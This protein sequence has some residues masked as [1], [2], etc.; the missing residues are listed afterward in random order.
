MRASHILSLATKVKPAIMLF[1]LLVSTSSIEA[2]AGGKGIYDIESVCKKE[3]NV[4]P[5]KFE[6][7][8]ID[9]CPSIVG[10]ENDYKV[11]NGGVHVYTF[12]SAI[13][14]YGDPVLRYYA[15]SKGHL[16]SV[17]DTM[18]VFV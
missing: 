10:T 17:T 7:S 16:V 15:Y 2:L 3:S 11:V 5:G 1:F 8:I 6:S 14:K 18:P 13:D 12:V 4:N 9:N